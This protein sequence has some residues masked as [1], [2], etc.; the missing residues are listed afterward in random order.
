MHHVS[1][2]KTNGDLERLGR[3]GTRIL[4]GVFGELP[5]S[6][7]ENADAVAVLEDYLSLGLAASS[8]KLQ[9]KKLGFPGVAL[10]PL[11]ARSLSDRS[12]RF[13]DLL[14]DWTKVCVAAGASGLVIILDELDVEYAATTWEGNQSLGRRARRAALLEALSGLQSE[15][16]PLLVAFA[17]APAGAGVEAE[18]DASRDIASVIGS[19]DEEIVAPIPRDSELRELGKKV[20]QLYR[21][22][23]PGSFS[24]GSSG[25]A[26]RIADLLVA[27][28]QR[29][30][31]PVPR[32]FVRSALEVMDVMSMGGV[33]RP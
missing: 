20:F 1:I 31:N 16:I 7:F 5:R 30:A 21:A 22:A 26:E 3:D 25:A 8:A 13:C 4:G 9:L 11:R 6:A 15:R 33:G 19:L 18:N 12:K 10:P 32:Y 23:Y 28:Y 24:R 17:A 14:H 29:R 2:A 27:W